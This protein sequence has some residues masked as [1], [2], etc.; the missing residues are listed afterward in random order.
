MQPNTTEAMQRMLAEIKQGLP[1][2]ES[3]AHLCSGLCL[4]CPKKVMAF[5]EDEVAAWEQAMAN[6]QIPTLGDL[7]QLGKTAKKIHRLMVKNKIIL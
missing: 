7:Q 3:E 2:G 4:G 6:G 1:F 5:I